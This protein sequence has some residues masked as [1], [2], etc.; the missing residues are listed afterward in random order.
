M[1][2]FSKS[3]I[4]EQLPRWKAR[5]CQHCFT[6]QQWFVELFRNAFGPI[7]VFIVAADKGDQ[8]TGVRNADHDRENPFRLDKSRGKP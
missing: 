8:K 5:F 7:I 1:P 3:R 2:S 4:R 6:S